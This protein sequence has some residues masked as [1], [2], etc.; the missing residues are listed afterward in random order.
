MI[1]RAIG[2][3]LRR[4]VEAATAH[5]PLPRI[6]A[7]RDGLSPYLSRWYL[8]GAPHMPDGSSPFDRFGNERVGAVW[9]KADGFGIYVHR[10]HRGDDDAA[11]HNHP[12]RLAASFVLAGGYVEERR[13]GAVVVQRVVEPLSINIISDN[14]FHRVDL[15]EHDAWTLFVVGPKVQSWGFWDRYDALG[16]VVPWREYVT[17]KRARANRE[18]T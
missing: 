7:D 3:V 12:W 15:I 5:L 10:F 14:D 6:I 9:P 2:R 16:R 8:W 13:V 4:I 1:R 11:L 17:A 18:A